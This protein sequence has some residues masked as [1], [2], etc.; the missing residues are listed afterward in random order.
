MF[1]HV[2]A[3]AHVMLHLPWALEDPIVS[4]MFW[5]HGLVFWYKKSFVPGN[6]F[7]IEELQVLP[8]TS[9]TSV[10]HRVR[11]VSTLIHVILQDILYQFFQFWVQGMI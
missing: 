3:M 11:H 9:A 1:R 6:H 10:A 4:Y 7:Q 8:Q 2:L 5:E